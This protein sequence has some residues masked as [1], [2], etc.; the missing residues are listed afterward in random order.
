MQKTVL[1]CLFFCLVINPI[2]AQKKTLSVLQISKKAKSYACNSPLKG[3]GIKG[4]LTE[5]TGNHMPSPNVKNPGKSGGV[6]RVL[7]I[8]PLANSKDFIEAKSGNGFYSGTKK[9]NPVAVIKSD[10]TGCFQC[11]LKPGRYTIMIIEKGKLYANIFDGDMNLNP[12]SVQAG[13]ITTHNLELSYQAS[14]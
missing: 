8:Y 4:I 13:S 12:F 9:I 1:L 14:F 7:V 3:T 11:P 2:W 10:A 5:L 6:S